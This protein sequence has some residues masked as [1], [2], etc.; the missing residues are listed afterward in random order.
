[1][2]G[3]HLDAS[4]ALLLCPTSQADLLEQTEP[5]RH[6]PSWTRQEAASSSYWTEDR[7]MGG[8][9]DIP[10]IRRLDK[11]ARKMDLLI[12]EIFEG[13]SIQFPVQIC[14]SF[15]LVGHGIMLLYHT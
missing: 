4:A 14:R 13:W 2:R 12:L 3:G 1:M 9:V 10:N 8:P 11:P 7:E 6:R 5:P 15:L